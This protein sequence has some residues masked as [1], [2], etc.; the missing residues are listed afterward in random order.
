MPPLPGL[1]P[2][3]FDPTT[4]L[5]E[6]LDLATH[7]PD[8]PL[9]VR[10]AASGIL[11]TGAGT[12][13]VFVLVP[14]GRLDQGAHKNRPGVDRNDEFAG[15]DELAGASVPLDPFLIARTELTVGQ[16]NRLLGASTLHDDPLLPIT[17]VDWSMARELLQRHGMALPTE[18]QWEY[19]ARAHGSWPWSS[20]PD[21]AEATS[22]GWFSGGMQPVG[23]LQPNRFGLY[24]LHGNAAEWCADVKLPYEDSTARRGDGLRTHAA[25]ASGEELRVLRGGAFYEGPQAARVTARAG[26]PPTTRSFGIGVRPVRRLRD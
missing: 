12:G 2:L 7:A 20:G 13:L 8:Y 1:L 15:D 23:L 11:S 4:R 9:P 25:G 3:G 10:D 14:G 19:A 26:K 21:P 6:F 5:H 17:N 18:A 16:W 22:C 24:D